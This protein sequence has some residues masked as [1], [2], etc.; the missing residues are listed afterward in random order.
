MLPGAAPTRQ[1][2]CQWMTREL[3]D[4][5]GQSAPSEGLLLGASRAGESGAAWEERRSRIP[6]HGIC[7]LPLCPPQDPYLRASFYATKVPELKRSCGLGTEVSLGLR[8]MSWASAN[9]NEGLLIWRG[10]CCAPSARGT[11]SRSHRAYTV[12]TQGSC[13]VQACFPL[14]QYDCG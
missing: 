10:S 11:L 3:T 9:V 1:L 4:A 14:H 8:Q 6:S 5:Q 7:L 2:G 13:P 12:S